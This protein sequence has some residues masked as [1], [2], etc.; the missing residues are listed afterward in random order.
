MKLVGEYARSSAALSKLKKMCANLQTAMYYSNLTVRTRED[1]LQMTRAVMAA[2]HRINPDQAVSSVRTMDDVLSNSVARPRL[3]FILLATFAGMAV[4]LAAVGV[5]GVLSYSVVQ[6]TQEI[7]IRVA[8]GATSTDVLYMV[9]KEGVVLLTIGVAVGISAALL[10]TRLLKSLL[11][12]V[13]P[14][15]ALTLVCVTA[16]LIAVALVAI[17]VPARRAFRL[18][19]MAA[20]RYE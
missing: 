3:Q 4:L 15:D 8:L 5:Y 7:G 18:D 19:A 2:I 17:F 16:I 14:T 9:L 12:E 6:R 11:F 13:L 20:L 1:P 10:L